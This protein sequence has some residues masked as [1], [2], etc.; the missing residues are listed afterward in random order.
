LDLPDAL[1]VERFRS[2]SERVSLPLRPLTLVYGANNSGKS[3]LLRALALLAASLEPAARGTI[4]FPERAFAD[5]Q[6]RDLAWQGDAGD[7]RWKLGLR[8]ANRYVQEFVATINPSVEGDVPLTA[9]EVVRHDAA[10]WLA[11]IGPDGFLVD[12][13]T[14][15]PLA[16]EGFVPS[17]KTTELADLRQQLVALG[18][19]IRWL[20][21]VR[22]PVP[23]I[24]GG[25]APSRG[26][27]TDGSEVPHLLVEDRALRDE[28][29]AFYAT[30]DPPRSLELHEVPHYG[31][32]FSL[33]PASRPSWR[34]HLR[35]TGEGMSQ[36]LPV[37][38]YAA[39]AAR[40]GGILAVEEPESH[41][42]P[43][44]QSHLAAYLC[45]LAKRST[46]PRFVIET[47]SRVV[48]LAVQRAVADGLPA[49]HV[50]IVWVDQDHDGRSTLT[51]I[52]LH[53]NGR[54]GD[55]WPP[56][57]LAEDLRLARELIRASR[58]PL[59]DS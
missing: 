26:Y 34:V 28:V 14:R 54:M 8:W 55:G 44:A 33:N 29:A 32:S 38:A 58:P 9:L 19:R 40:E 30:L 17:A 31:Y 37:L 35:D 49:E 24:I 39:L 23:R 1:V 7:Y 20:A 56:S 12:P 2:F 42:H 3:A 57:A 41:L 27:A 45:A 50:Q 18:G 21:S 10:R 6:P 46:G 22:P 5:I 25:P 53:A 36:V 13:D 16:F 48:L 43:S 4:T 51:A 59:E 11:R 52:P 15:A 47:H